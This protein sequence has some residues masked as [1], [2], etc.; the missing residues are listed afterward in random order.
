MDIE[1]IYLLHLFH[2]VLDKLQA[3]L[4]H[5]QKGFRPGSGCGLFH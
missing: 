5:F 1:Y 2:Q 4:G 3:R